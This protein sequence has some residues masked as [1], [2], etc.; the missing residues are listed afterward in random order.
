[1]TSNLNPSLFLLILSISFYNLT[2][3]QQSFEP[4]YIITKQGVKKECLIDNKDWG[5]SPQ[6][7]QYKSNEAGSVQTATPADIRE[8]GLINKVRYVSASVKIDESSDQVYSMTKERNPIWS[9][10]RLFLKVLVDGDADLLFYGENSMQRFFFRTPSNDSIR[11]L[12]Y[13]RYL[14]ADNAVAS[15]SYFQQQL[16]REINCENHNISW[17]DKIRYSTSSLGRYF[18]EYNQ[19]KG[20]SP[21]VNLISQSRDLF[22]FRINPGISMSSISLESEV[23]EFSDLDFGSDLNFRIGLEF[24]FVFPQKKE[25]WALLFEPVLQFYSSETTIDSEQVSLSLSS[26][27]FTVGARRYLQLNNDD[28]FFELLYVPGFNVDFNTTIDYQSGTT[29]EILA[30]HGLALGFGWQS[31]QIQVGARYYLPRSLGE[32][33]SALKIPFSAFHLFA[34][35]QIW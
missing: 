21:S 7:I 12:V 34:G 15:N 17:F 26:L 10:K 29:L 30:R 5:N 19:C 23:S 13:K 9:Q 8:F 4:G 31:D 1:M 35:V 22:H 33:Y 32:Q 11:Q 20:V 25:Q 18:L 14:A 28:L 24:E 3:A 2:Q 6:D 16:W 27:D